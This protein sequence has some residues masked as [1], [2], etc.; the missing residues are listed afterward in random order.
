MKMETPSHIAF[1]SLEETKNKE[2][3]L[4]AILVTDLSGV[5]LEFR[6]THPVKP[7]LVQKPLYGESLKPFIGNELCGKPLIK[8]LQNKP[9]CIIVNTNLFL[10][11]RPEISIPVLFARRA[12][13]TIDVDSKQ[14]QGDRTPRKR[15]ESPTGDFQP[16]VCL[17]HQDYPEDFDKLS[18]IFDSS[19]RLLDIVEPFTRVKTAVEV[20][21]KQDNRFE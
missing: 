5:P 7:T 13:E 18:A 21:S 6:C 9:S 4:G 2:G 12:G 19:S 8:S 10:S 14:K 20:L 16:I 11:L 15:L 3:Y 1:L 17:C